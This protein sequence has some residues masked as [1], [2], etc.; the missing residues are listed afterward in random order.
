[1]WFSV[2]MLMVLSWYEPADAICAQ[3][4]IESEACDEK[5]REDQQP[6]DGLHWDAGERA[7]VV[8]IPHHPVGCSIKPYNS[9]SVKM[10]DELQ[11]N[12]LLVF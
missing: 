12:V 1:M 8:C 5:D 2:L 10:D 11:R 9:L 6:V 3:D 4:R 7:L